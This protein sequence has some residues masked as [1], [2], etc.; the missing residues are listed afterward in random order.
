MAKR[1]EEERKLLQPNMREMKLPSRKA[2]KKTTG[3]KGKGKGGGGGGG[4][5]AK[6]A[7]VRTAAQQHHDLCADTVR[8]D[9]VCIVKDVLGKDS[10]ARMYDCLADELER[11][12][13]AVEDDPSVCPQRFPPIP[14]SM[15][16]RKKAKAAAA[17]SSASA[18]ARRTGAPT[19]RSMRS[20]CC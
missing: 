14:S 10:A 20:R 1:A 6:G 8:D 17:G 15:T 3:K 7:V 18:S 12:Y 16:V 13:A 9:G 11:A 2:L 5:F 4:G 19:S